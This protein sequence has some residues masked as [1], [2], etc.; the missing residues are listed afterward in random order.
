M[1]ASQKDFIKWLAKKCQAAICQSTES[2]AC[3]DYGSK[4]NKFHKPCS[5]LTE[6][7]LVE[8]AKDRFKYELSRERGEKNDNDRVNKVT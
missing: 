7:D 2:C 5:N 6:N 1:A 4:N 3:C 8:L